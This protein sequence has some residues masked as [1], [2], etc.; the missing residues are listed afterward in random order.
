MGE[1]YPTLRYSDTLFE[2][3]KNGV[4]TVECNSWKEFEDRIGEFKKKNYKYLW[5]G[6]SCERPL[7]PSVYRD[8]TPDD[9]R[10]KQHLSQFKKDMPRAADLEEF[11]RRAKT[12]QTKEF[13]KALSK[14]Y[15]MI[16]AKA[17]DND[18]KE[19]YVTD[20]I[21][22]IYWAIGQHH[23]LKTP[24]LD[25]TTDPYKA[26]FFAF[27]KEEEKNNNRVVFGLAEKSIR[28]FQKKGK[29][30][31]YIRFLSNLDFVHTILNGFHGSPDFKE[32]IGSMFRRIE[33]QNGMFTCSLH[34]IEE[35]EKH[36][37]RCYRHF[38]NKKN[39]KDEIVFLIKIMVPNS[40]RESV[41][42]ELE[43][44]K[45]ITYKTMYPDLQGAALCCNLKLDL[46]Q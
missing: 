27:C 26:L 45:G 11:L 21:N 39:Q 17:D 10:V 13:E 41:L 22:D 44:K 35:V 9:N 29:T 4:W 24:L 8:C 43:G 46:S 40:I 15:K 38:R 28:L 5:R 20:F 18:P 25:W 14:Y 19:N 6:Q 32:R 30:K 16:R 37:K 23:G 3:S 2:E 12:E 31:R 7:L 36:A 1:K 34:N 42:E 33:S